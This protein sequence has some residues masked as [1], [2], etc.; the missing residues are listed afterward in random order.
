[1]FSGCTVPPDSKEMELG[2]SDLEASPSAGKKYWGS[3]SAIFMHGSVSLQLFPVVRSLFLDIYFLTSSE[4]GVSL[5][6][7]GHPSSD[8]VTTKMPYGVDVLC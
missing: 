4:E 6:F 7:V 8:V 3:F 5:A 1:M 2:S